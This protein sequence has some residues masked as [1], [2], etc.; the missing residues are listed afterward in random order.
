MHSRVGA[1]RGLRLGVQVGE[2]VDTVADLMTVKDVAKA[3]AGSAPGR[4]NA[5]WPNS[6]SR[7][8]GRRA[9]TSSGFDAP[10]SSG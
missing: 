2:G 4:F 9:S 1:L 6:G 10:R 8:S 5:W 3:L 7:W